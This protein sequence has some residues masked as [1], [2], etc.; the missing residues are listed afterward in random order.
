IAEESG[1]IYSKSFACGCHGISCYGMGF[2]EEAKTLF[3]N[4]IDLTNKIDHHYWNADDNQ[5]LAEIYYEMGKYQMAK[6]H[7]EKAIKSIERIG[8]LPSWINFNKIAIARAKVMNHEKDI[9]LE[10]LYSFIPKNKVKL[11]EG[12]IQRY[13]GEILLNIDDQHTSEAEHWIQKAIEADQRNR[14]MFH[15]G[16]DYVLYA[17]LFRR[18][19][20]ILKAQENLG[21]AIEIFKECGAD[22]WVEK[23]EKE[24][25]AIS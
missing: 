22:G 25:A 14:M 18:K 1:D 4:G 11:Y 15:L 8:W 3:L 12:W 13:I 24:L 6:D 9:D 2:L 23:Y 7:Y 17:E 5:F 10:S 16:K 21:R 20:D 19:G